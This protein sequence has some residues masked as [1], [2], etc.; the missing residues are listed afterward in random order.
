MKILLFVLLTTAPAVADG[1]GIIESLYS[2]KEFALSA[3]PAAAQWNN[4]KPVVAEND[5]YG[6]PTPGHRTEIRARWT[7]KNLYLLYVCAYQQLYLIENPVTKNE[8]NKLWDH[9][10][11]EVFAGAEFD[12][13]WRYREYQMS[14]QAEWVDLDIDRKKSSPEGGWTWN[15]GFEVKARIDKERKIWYGEMRIP[16]ASFDARAPKAGNEIR[17]NFYRLQGPPPKRNFVAWQPT[18]GPSY[19]VPEAFG[20]MRLVK[21]SK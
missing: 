21:G 11:A 10:V 5:Q 18:N 20:R 17:I 14:P 3:D 1:P 4:I 6:K 16:I 12:R 9:D 2:A 15:S 19:H 8:T 7:D 13:I